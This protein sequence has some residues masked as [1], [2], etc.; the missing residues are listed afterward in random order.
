MQ[1]VCEQGSWYTRVCE[2][3]VRSWPACSSYLA[4]V[5]VDVRPALYPSSAR[6][7]RNKGMIDSVGHF[8]SMY[9]LKRS[10]A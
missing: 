8:G 6:G 9:F 10:D 5:A 1:V 3:H 7:L 2:C 4:F